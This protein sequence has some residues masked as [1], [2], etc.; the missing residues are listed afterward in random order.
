MSARQ[1]AP[2]LDRFRRPLFPGVKVE[3]H[4]RLP[5]VFDIADVTP[6]VDPRQ[7]A[8][9]WQITLTTSVA[10]NAFGGT[11]IEEL[12]AVVFPKAVDGDRK[13]DEV[14]S[15]SFKNP[16]VGS[17]VGS[18]QDDDSPAGESEYHPPNG[19]DDEQHDDE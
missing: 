10:F 6:V 17:I 9:L 1:A 15:A 4:P 2:L 14:E 8:G 13:P 12:T 11:P 19:H 18:K 3:F 5:L 7:P 16:I